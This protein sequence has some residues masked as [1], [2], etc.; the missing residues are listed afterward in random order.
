MLV[1][2]LSAKLGLVTGRRNLAGL[3]ALGLKVPE[4]AK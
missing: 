3:S 1:Q 2:A 4:F